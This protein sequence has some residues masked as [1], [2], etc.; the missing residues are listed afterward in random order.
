[1][2]LPLQDF[3]NRRAIFPHGSLF[4]VA[5]G[6][7]N[8]VRDAKVQAIKRL[9]KL[10]ISVKLTVMVVQKPHSSYPLLPTDNRDPHRSEN[11]VP[12][13]VVDN[14]IMLPSQFMFI[15]KHT[16]VFRVCRVQLHVINDQAGITIDALLIC[17]SSQRGEHFLSR[18]LLY[19]P[20]GT[21]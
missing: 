14:T 21:L 16:L 20:W 5:S 11:C 2:L 3:K 12:G 9:A 1:L 7:F 17:V 18:L 6:Q 19:G 10:S 15:C 4:G 13:K 8:Q